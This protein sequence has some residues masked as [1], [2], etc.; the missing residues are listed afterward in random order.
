MQYN[1]KFYINKSLL[2]FDNNYIDH[3]TYK[4]KCIDLITIN[5]KRCINTNKFGI[6]LSITI[7][8]LNYTLQCTNK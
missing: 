3:Y 4:Y 8:N 6:Y 2:I 1:I 5:K 7:N